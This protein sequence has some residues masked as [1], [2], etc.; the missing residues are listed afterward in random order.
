[1][2]LLYPKYEST[3]PPIVYPG[4]S[5]AECAGPRSPAAETAP[6]APA[7]GSA[8]S[9]SPPPPLPRAAW[10]RKGGRKS[11]R[12]RASP[13]LPTCVSEGTPQSRAPPGD[14]GPSPDVLP[15]A[16]DDDDDA[17]SLRGGSSA[18]SP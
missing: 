9:S 18:A 8:G 4:C 3:K 13:S 16:A 15:A 14:T 1:M 6:P 7:P 17:Q 2:C 12:E 11:P 5:P 10:T